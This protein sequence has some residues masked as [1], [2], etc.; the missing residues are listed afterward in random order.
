M[1]LGRDLVASIVPELQ[2]VLKAEL[3]ED[4]L[5][6]VFDFAQTAMLDSSGIGLLIATHN[7]LSRRQGRIRLINVAPDILQLLQTMRLINRLNATG[8]NAA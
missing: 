8:H 6:V 3:Q 7:S 2:A 5:E 1:T 4:G